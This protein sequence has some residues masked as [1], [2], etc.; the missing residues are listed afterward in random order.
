[1][2]F[3]NPWLLL[4]IA[5]IASP[6]IIHL[7]AKRQVK[8]VVWAA[9]RF[10][11]ATVDRNQRKMTL[12]D[13]LLLVMRCLVLALIA[14]ALARPTL[15]SAGFGR[16]GA[17]ETAIVLLDQSGSMSTTDGGQ[18]RFEK[19][20]KAADQII[21]A[22]P[23]GSSIAI[24]LISD[25]IRAVIPEPTRDLSL[26]RKSIREA[27]RSDQATEW[28]P[29]I[30]KA[31]EVLSRQSS[32]SRQLYVLTDGQ[33]AGWK[34][35][36]EARSL[37]ESAKQT[38]QSRLVLIN[39]NE[40]KNVAI[41]SIRLA[42]ALA[43]AGQPLRFE[44]GVAN[45]GP[46]EV[47]DVQVSLA[48]DD[49]PAGEEQTLESLPPTGEPRMVSLFAVFSEAGSH[50]VTAR[51]RTDR[52]PFDDT[53][54]FA[55]KVSGDVNVLLVDGDPG[56]EPRDSEVFYL[57]NA[58][59]PVAPEL[60]DRYFV[61]TKTIGTAEV[62]RVSL[63]EFDAV[64]LANIVDLSPTA[65]SALETWVRT[66]GGLMVFPGSRIS[67]AF[68]NDRLY[69]QTGLLPA[70]FGEPRGEQ[71]DETKAERPSTYFVLQG[72][73]YTHRV[74][75]PWADPKNGTLSTA[76][77]YRA[78]PLL[79][80]R[81]NALAGESGPAAVVLSFADG[82][83][84]IMER[85]FGA[86]RVLQ[87]SSTAD[88][89]WNDLPIRP[90]FVPL[91][92]RALGYLLARAEDRYNTRAGTPFS[93]ACGAELAGRESRVIAPGQALDSAPPRRLDM[94]NQTP[95][96][97]HEDTSIAGAYRVQFPENGQADFRFAVQ[98]DP[99]ESALVELP[100]SDLRQ[101]DQVAPVIR[102]SPGVDLRGVIQQDRAGTELWLPAL[103][104][105]LGIVLAETVLANRW[106]RSK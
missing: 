48:M 51:I 21:D 62:D 95:V 26:A 98:S 66:G 6:I 13:I 5:G 94:Q 71:I 37:L 89:G 101:L 3:L 103:F 47:K 55:L 100:A 31:L 64:I 10:L 46:E 11:K 18:S 56:I 60:R 22:L 102:W 40:E 4:G 73:G 77:F 53:R 12:E 91:M 82:S 43:P 50:T 35:L 65:T 39:E 33:A 72:K 17:S 105:V 68:Y 29:A 106:S 67:A 8:R 88:T 83:P 74:T 97:R 23:S 30:R 19:A 16:I 41:T 45:F 42:S 85:A 69:A 2:T 79:P 44:V 61:K 1:M 84:A 75:L 76:Q 92:H 86:G 25:Q 90:V 54:S 14:F 32:G 78:F 99:S 104:A 59:T 9:M 70:A 96:L 58:L 36:S 34:S 38:V 49:Q 63:S 57:R 24:W 27:K 15:R 52:C 87:F 7:L 81:P 93:M 80:A 20:Q 28:T